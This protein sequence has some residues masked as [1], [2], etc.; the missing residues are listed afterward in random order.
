[1]CLEA[2]YAEQLPTEPPIMAM[3]LCSLL[4]CAA[5]ENRQME[6]ETTTLSGSQAVS[7]TLIKDC[8]F[9]HFEMG[10]LRVSREVSRLLVLL[11]EGAE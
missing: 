5:T 4:I 10:S 9:I 2:G 3:F 1:M 7:W 8:A 6:L 11:L